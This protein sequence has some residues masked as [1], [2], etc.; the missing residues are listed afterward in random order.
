[1]SKPSSSRI[2]IRCFHHVSSKVS[3]DAAPTSSGI[4]NFL[5]NNSKT[6]Q[7]STF[8]TWISN[9]RKTYLPVSPNVPRIFEKLDPNAKLSPNRI[10][11]GF[12]YISFKG[13]E[14]G[15]KNFAKN[16]IQNPVGA[17]R[18]TFLR[19]R[20]AA[21]LHIEAFWKRNYL[22]ILGAGGV[23]VC[24]LLWRVLFGIA[25]TFISLSEGMAKY[26]FLALSAAMVA[27]AV[28]VLATPTPSSS[29]G[30]DSSKPA[31]EGVTLKEKFSVPESSS[32]PMDEPPSSQG[33][34]PPDVEAKDVLMS[35]PVAA[36]SSHLDKG[37]SSQM[38]EPEVADL[39]WDMPS[40]KIVDEVIFASPLPP[41]CLV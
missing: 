31:D 38:V 3:A 14:V 18:N 15:S 13:Y 29:A 21:G 17:V 41:L 30:A 4:S 27:F 25:S 28:L 24:I 39:A 26:G 23:V 36:R 33:V 1:M 37:K 35:L 12:R 11:L 20:E 10:F 16:V 2:I 7:S 40:S 22:A 34:D 9:S 6:N 19:Y 32:Q 5:S 8:S